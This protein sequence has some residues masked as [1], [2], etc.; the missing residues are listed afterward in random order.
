MDTNIEVN[1]ERHGKVRVGGRAQARA[2]VQWTVG[3]AGGWG[4][5]IPPNHPPQHTPLQA[6]FK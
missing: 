6:Y 4:D 3:G 1:H 5:C 2:Y